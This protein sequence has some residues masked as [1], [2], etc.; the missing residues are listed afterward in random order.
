MGSEMCIRDRCTFYILWLYRH[1]PNELVT[2]S[3]SLSPTK[4]PDQATRTAMER[5]AP[6]APRARSQMRTVPA[7]LDWRPPAPRHI[8]NTNNSSR[9]DAGLR[10][11]RATLQGA[12][13]GL[14]SH[15]TPGRSVAPPL[16]TSGHGTSTKEPASH[17][18]HR[19]AGS[20]G[21]KIHK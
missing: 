12:I 10:S 9:P 17:A 15:P 5:G 8:K 21:R 18:L 6:R 19:F 4:D 14:F 2:G 7:A 16:Q 1:L 3:T 11:L 20:G 13:R